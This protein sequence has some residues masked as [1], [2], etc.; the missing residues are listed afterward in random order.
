MSFNLLS[1]NGYL[2]RLQRYLS[3]SIQLAWPFIILQNDNITTLWDFFRLTASR[4]LGMTAGA[5][6]HSAR[7]NLKS[8]KK[9]CPVA[10][11][12]LLT[13]CA[14]WGE[15]G[16]APDHSAIQLGWCSRLTFW[17]IIHAN[18]RFFDEVDKIFGH[19][20]QELGRVEAFHWTSS[21]SLMSTFI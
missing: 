3:R 14:S 18:R 4:C 7:M 13:H 15:G 21:F 20:F 5:V 12:E 10:R 9:H 2:G 17:F 1:V 16:G 8:E 11:F 6:T 19:G